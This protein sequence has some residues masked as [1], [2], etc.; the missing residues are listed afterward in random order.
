VEEEFSSDFNHLNVRGQAVE[1]ELVWPVVA[2]MLG[3]DEATA[4]S[5]VL[6]TERES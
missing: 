4:S 2:E 1:A 5:A 3:L 6:S